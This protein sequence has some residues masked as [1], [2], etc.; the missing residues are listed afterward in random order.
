M[1]KPTWIPHNWQNF[2]LTFPFTVHKN[3]LRCNTHTNAHTYLT[4]PKSVTDKWCKE[5]WLHIATVYI[6]V[7]KSA[8]ILLRRTKEE[9]K[10]VMNSRQEQ[11]CSHLHKIHFTCSLIMNETC[12]TVKLVHT[13]WCTV[14][15]IIKTWLLMHDR[16]YLKMY[17][18]VPTSSLSFT[19]KHV[20]VGGWSKQEVGGKKSK[21]EL[22]RNK[23][24]QFK[25]ETGFTTFTA[26]TSQIENKVQE[27][28]ILLYLLTYQ[29]LCR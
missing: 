24:F 16:T 23:I 9:Q 19:Q 28:F 25:C 20:K 17:R 7:S 15:I 5:Y 21:L 14:R 10:W 27:A 6:F 29:A 3:Q 12:F 18:N 8:D 1:A 2:L 11:E 26:P 4:I 22:L 13:M